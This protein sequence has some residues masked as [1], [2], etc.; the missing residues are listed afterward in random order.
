M[1]R[2]DLLLA[3]SFAGYHGDRATFTQLYIEHRI[4]HAPAQ[5][6]YRAGARQRAG[7]VRCECTDCKKEATS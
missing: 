7:G 6:A 1:K 2:A 5:A 4:G 3:M